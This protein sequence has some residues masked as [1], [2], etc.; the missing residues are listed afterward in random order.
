MIIGMESQSR[1]IF[2]DVRQAPFKFHLTGSRFFA[3]EYVSQNTTDYDFFVLHSLSLMSWL[4]INRFQ[5]LSRYDG[6]YSEI[7]RDPHILA[8]YRLIPNNTPQVDI[9]IIRNEYSY[10]VKQIANDVIK[11]IIP[12]LVYNGM[13]KTDRGAVWR[14]TYKFVMNKLL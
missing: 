6:E 13:S 2:D 10:K 5:K 14:S 4:N 3:P 12:S 8:V 7:R 11:A 9:Q 1:N